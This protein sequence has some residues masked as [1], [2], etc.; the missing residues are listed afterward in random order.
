MVA[1]AAVCRS[2]IA[3]PGDRTSGEMFVDDRHCMCHTQN[4]II[5][6][7]EV[8]AMP[9]KFAFDLGSYG[10]LVVFGSDILS[11]C[12][13]DTRTGSQCDLLSVIS[14]YIPH[15]LRKQLLVDLRSLFL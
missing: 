4:T 12:R 11:I 2:Q 15:A 8:V 6:P 5:V 7:L 9:P 1:W 10:G 13:K 14:I 3:K